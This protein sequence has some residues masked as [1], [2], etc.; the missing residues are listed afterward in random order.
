MYGGCTWG[1]GGG[2]DSVWMY[3]GCIWR[4]CGGVVMVGECMMGAHG[5]GWG[6]DGHATF[7]FG[8]SLK[9]V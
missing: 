8:M 9:T 2:G 3:H 4:E 1:G 5:D 6:G 7:L